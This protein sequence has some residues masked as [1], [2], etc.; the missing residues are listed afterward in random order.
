MFEGNEGI[1]FKVLGLLDDLLHAHRLNA[2]VS[3]HSS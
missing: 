1:I 2:A 3:I